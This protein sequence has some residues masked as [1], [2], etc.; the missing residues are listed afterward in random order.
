M[1]R[2]P[3]DDSFFN[4]WSQRKR[5]ARAD[6]PTPV[7]SEDADAE[8][9][10]EDASGEKPPAVPRA[11]TEEELA[12]L[13]PVEEL[14]PQ[15]DLRP[16]LRPGVPEAL[17]NAAR[18]RMWSLTPAIRDHADPAVDYAWD[19]NTPGGVPGD[20]VAPLREVARRMLDDLRATDRTAEKTVSPATDADKASASVGGADQPA[21]EG[22]HGAAAPGNA[23]PDETAHKEARLQDQTERRT[24]NDAARPADVSDDS[25]RE[26]GPP[27][28]PARHGGAL[29]Q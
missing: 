23:P 15:S 17:K 22:P 7:Q 10:R 29:P 24:S 6:L 1:A 8:D 26:S 9:S 21:P 2:A 13:P 28:R 4:R 14:T 25:G 20:G 12:A 16:F 3:D 5:A 18:R 19:W 11:I 27:Q